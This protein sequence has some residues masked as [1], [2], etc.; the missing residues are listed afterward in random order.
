M[1]SLMSMVPMMVGTGARRFRNGESHHVISKITFR[2]QRHTRDLFWV[3]C[4][5]SRRDG[6]REGRDSSTRT[7]PCYTAQI[8]PFQYNAV[9]LRKLQLRV[10]SSS[11][12]EQI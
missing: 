12:R 7:K 2:D 4:S 8:G 9:A 10:P 5:A 11:Y 6:L 1:M 3:S